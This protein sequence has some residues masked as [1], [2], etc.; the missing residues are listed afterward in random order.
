MWTSTSW[1]RVSIKGSAGLLRAQTPPASGNVSDGSI[2]SVSVPETGVSGPPPPVTI[3][4]LSDDRGGGSQSVSFRHRLRT[5][6]HR[7]QRSQGPRRCRAHLP[8]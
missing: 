1:R 3:Q 8:A 7:L 5:C 2:P 4:S 6:A